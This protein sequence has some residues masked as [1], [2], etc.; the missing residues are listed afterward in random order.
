M[1]HV[2]SALAAY[3]RSLTPFTSAFDQYIS[4][5]DNALSPSAKNGFNIFM[6]KA[7]CGKCHFAPVF[8]GLMPPFYTTTEF[9][10]TG[11]PVNSDFA[12]PLM[13][14]DMGRYHIVPVESYRRAFKTP[15]VRDAAVTAPY[16]HNGVLPTLTSLIDFYDKGGGAGIGLNV[17][18][19]T[20]LPSPLNLTNEEKSE[21]T[22]FIES[23]T[24]K[25]I[26]K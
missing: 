1:A 22:A 23:L 21:L 18:E 16:M 6:G 3:V 4:G 26:Q 13:D 17:P 25:Q 7:G 8:N 10:V 19:Q 9:E 5:D 2:A 11:T 24:D 14:S 20:L 15:T 12:K